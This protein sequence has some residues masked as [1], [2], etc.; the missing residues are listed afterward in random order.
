MASPYSYSPVQ[1]TYLP[2]PRHGTI[3]KSPLASTFSINSSAS[4]KSLPAIPS[5]TGHHVHIHGRS[6]FQVWWKELATC[7]II[8]AALF[9]IVGTVLPYQDQ[10]LPNWPY[11]LSINTL[12]SIYVAILK[13]AMAFVLAECIGQIKWT[14]FEHPR[15]LTDLVPYDDASRGSLWGSL[16]LLWMLRGRSALASVGA[17]VTVL[18]AIIDPFAQQLVQY[19]ACPQL[20]HTQNASIPIANMW[21]SNSLRM[22]AGPMRSTLGYEMQAAIIGGMLPNQ[23]FE[24][25][26][27]CAT[28]N[29]TFPDIYYSLGYCAIC[30]D[31]TDEMEFAASEVVTMTQTE[32]LAATVEGYTSLVTSFAT[33][34]DSGSTATTTFTG[35]ATIT[36]DA[37]VGTTQTGF[38]VAV[39]TAV[40][41]GMAKLPS[42]LMAGEQQQF[43]MNVSS[44]SP[45]GD[46]PAGDSSDPMVGN[47]SSS[48]DIEFMSNVAGAKNQSAANSPD[49]LWTARGYGAARCSLEPCVQGFNTTVNGG[50]LQETLVSTSYNSTWAEIMA[51][52]SF[53]LTRTACL[54]DP[55]QISS[56]EQQSGLSRNQWPAY[57]PYNPSWNG[58]NGTLWPDHDPYMPANC[59]FSVS[60]ADW[61]ATLSFFQTYFTGW[62]SVQ[63]GV[64]ST[65]MQQDAFFR[66]GNITFNTVN[67]TVQNMARAMSNVMRQGS[68]SRAAMGQTTVQATCVHADWQWLSF[69]AT[70]TGLTLLCFL[71]TSIITHRRAGDELRAHDF[72]TSVLP[73]MFAANKLQE[74][75]KNV[76][77]SGVASKVEKSLK[78]RHVRF[79]RGDDGWHF[80]EEPAIVA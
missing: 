63:G 19:Y 61:F 64:A 76:Q 48:I 31:V 73:L 14:W 55:A 46:S 9:A 40:F 68:F 24:P 62:I 3:G 17:I 60:S 16:R 72:K 53:I 7:F 71:L 6:F 45:A 30:E 35:D 18:S 23:N 77:C 36:A 21:A 70:L 34:I 44:N 4:Q 52:Q 47:F 29:C 10:P 25:S 78:K 41:Q 59:S 80:T 49:T 66:S 67:S 75:A 69:P 1:P 2:P 28:G 5:S 20:S 27:T 50:K 79:E 32:P 12:V 42:G 57:L 33:W 22:G 74:P 51:M 65:R 11:D 38:A 37:Q 13:F 15:P 8:L 56:L 43:V 58:H 26:F 54:T 39:E